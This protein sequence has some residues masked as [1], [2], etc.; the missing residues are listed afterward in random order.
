M[1]KRLHAGKAAESGL[2][3]TQLAATGY[4]GPRSILEGR[5]GFL[6][7]FARRS[8]VR[9][10]TRPLGQRYEIATN[11]SFKPYACCSN[12]FAVIDA[13]KHLMA[14]VGF[15]ADVV[16]E[17]TVFGN[18]DQVQ[19]HAERVRISTIGAAQYSIPY[20]VAVTLIGAIDEPSVAFGKEML[21]DSRIAALCRKTTVRLDPKIDALFPQCEAARVVVRLT[22]GKRLERTVRYAKGSPKNRL[23]QDELEGKFERLT[24][25]VF[26]PA[27]ATQIRATVEKLE[28]IGDVRAL[29]R[30]LGGTGA[31]IESV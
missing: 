30:L 22:G 24:R 20:A 29:L 15:D 26:Q 7:T 5:Q 4:R 25:G 9:K 11:I 6:Q 2:L 3:A 28:S 21:C 8:D 1:I 31:N 10:L 13:V 17:V 14:T 27:A 18:R 23:S 12:L 19:Y 16:R